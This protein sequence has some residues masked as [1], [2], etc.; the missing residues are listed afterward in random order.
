MK[1]FLV[2]TLDSK[3]IYSTLLRKEE[4]VRVMIDKLF[5]ENKTIIFFKEVEY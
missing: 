4:T 2:T 3:G 1:Y 5:E